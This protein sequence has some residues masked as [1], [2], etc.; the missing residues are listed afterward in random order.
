MILPTLPQY[1]SDLGGS[2][3]EIGL[4]MGAFAVGLLA[5]RSYLGRLADTRSRKL[6][7][8]V[9]MFAV[10]LPPL[11]YWLVPQIQGLMILRAFHG[12][13]IA[14]FATSFVALVV[15]LSPEKYRGEVLGYMSLVNPIGTGLGP[16]I[17]GLLK[18]FGYTT[19]F[20]TATSVGLLGLGFLIPVTEPDRPMVSAQP[21]TQYWSLLINP[22]I[23]SLALVM[24][25]IGLAFGT[26]V[27]FS[28]L[29]VKESGLD[30][31]VELLYG[32]SAIASFMIRIIAG[33]ASDRWG[34]G[35][36]ITL[37]LIFFTVSMTLFAA[38][39]TSYVFILAALIQGAGFGMLIPMM[40]TLVADRSL[41][42]ERAR[43]FSACMIGFDLG[44]G[45]AGPILGTLTVGGSY[46]DAFEI[47]AVLALSSLVFFMLTSNTSWIQS[48]RFA[49]GLGRDE[50]ALKDFRRSVEA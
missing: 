46:Q 10:L 11:G 32:V 15:D 5:S 41:A 17:A 28:P 47:A 24:L 1:V 50:Y 30:L 9:G 25:L 34:R 8:I 23:R 42:Q 13:S 45:L 33:P 7:M 4:V 18:D 3:Q 27:T 39:Q 19:I 2:S 20:L 12:V 26:L 14:A 31:R 37:S 16:A 21:P 22:K 49:L 6:V 38:A 48:L 29:L 35:P 40:S 43:L 36:F 44:I